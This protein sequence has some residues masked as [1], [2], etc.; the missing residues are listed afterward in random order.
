MI[1][2]GYD[3]YMHLL[4]AGGVP[5]RACTV[6]GHM[7]SGKYVL[8]KD[9]IPVSEEGIKIREQTIRKLSELKDRDIK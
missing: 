3:T 5:V 6:C 2:I 7:W 8:I 1:L 4:K 9:W